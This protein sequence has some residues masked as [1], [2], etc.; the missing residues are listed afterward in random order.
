MTVALVMPTSVDPLRQALAAA[1]EKAAEAR[2]ALQHHRSAIER[3]HASVR[4]GEHRIKAT[5][6]ALADA[7]EA[8]ASALAAAAADDTP[9]P[10]S[11]VHAARQAITDAKDDVEAEK[12]ALARLRAALPDWERAA[13]EAD[14]EHETAVTAVLE[15]H[16]RRLLGQAWELRNKLAP[17]RRTLFALFNDRP[18]TAKNDLGFAKG[19]QQLDV[20]REEVSKFFGSFGDIDE[21][22]A[23]PWRQA[24]EL[25]RADP[26]AV[27]NFA[28]LPQ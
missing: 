17:I 20:I 10:T 2:E 24:R 22:T 25:L 23:E 9:P 3:I 21:V 5:Q 13:R 7:Q 28:E 16:M 19:Q 27:L 8:H 12:T 15:P 18:E 6:K 14:I 4:H 11:G 1:A 26:H